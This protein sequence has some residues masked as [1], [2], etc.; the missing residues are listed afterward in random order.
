[1]KIVALGDSITAGFP[2]TESDSWTAI[3]AWKLKCKVINQGI[4]GDDTWGMHNRFGHDV[5]RHQPSHVTIMGGSNDAASRLALSSVS[6]HFIAMIDM[7]RENGIVPILGMP[8]PILEE[9]GEHC[10]SQY[11]DWMRNYAAEQNI[12]IIDFYKP[13]QERVDAGQYIE[14]YC[15]LAHPSIS[16]YALMG[17]IAVERFRNLFS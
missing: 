14:L 2:Y 6:A 17:D 13:F 3:L 1:M 4:N 15:D 11:R 10:L 8:L 12:F 9:Q 7:C 16:G 5:L